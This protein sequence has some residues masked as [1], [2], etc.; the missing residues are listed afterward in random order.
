MLDAHAVRFNPFTG[1]PDYTSDGSN[2]ILVPMGFDTKCTAAEAA[3][4]PVIFSPTVDDTVIKLDDNSYG[5]DLVIGII[6]QKLT[7]TTCRVIMIGV[8]DN[9]ATGLTRGKPVW[10]S[11]TG[12]LTTTKPTSGDLQIL[13]NAFSSTGILVNIESRKTVLA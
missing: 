12:G 13:G 4:D 1:Q 9:I 2:T 6:Q 5:G 8:L 11:E 7:I 3:G 10:V